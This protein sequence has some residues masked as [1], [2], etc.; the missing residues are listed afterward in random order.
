MKVICANFK[1]QFYYWR[2]SNKNEVDL[3]I[4]NENGLFAYEIKSA[5]TMNSKF[6]DNLDQF[7]TLAKIPAENTA[8]IYTGDKSFTGGK[9]NFIRWNEIAT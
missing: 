6:Y 8:V 2:D 1:P 7:A 3:L 5:E 9:R 4:E